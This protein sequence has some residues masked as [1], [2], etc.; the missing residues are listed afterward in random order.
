MSPNTGQNPSSDTSAVP[1]QD[2][3]VGFR[4]AA[5]GVTDVGLRRTENQDS[6]LITPTVFAVADGMGGHEAGELASA[7]AVETLEELTF[8]TDRTPENPL[9]SQEQVRKQ[10]QLADDRI[11]E[12]L[13]A[14]GGTT[15]CAL[16]QVRG[17][18]AA[19]DTITAPIAVPPW[20]SSF[21]REQTRTDVLPQVTAN[22][23]DDYRPGPNNA[24]SVRPQPSLL[25]VNVGDSRGYRLRDGVLQQLTRDHSAVQEMIDAGQITELE[26]RNH[27]HRNLIT[28]ALGAGADSQPDTMMLRARIGDRYLLCSDGLSGEL[29]PEHLHALLEAYADPQA[30]ALA[31]TQAALE[32]GGRDNI[33]VIVI[34]VLPLDAPP[35]GGE[36]Q[37]ATTAQLPTVDLPGSTN[38]AQDPET[39]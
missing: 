35:A 38:P 2:A 18:E 32:A 11:R 8:Y 3:Q 27:P 19:R 12:A 30:A 24:Q 37:P 25:L 7:L 22:M 31:L 26:A 4:L 23:L 9:P 5:D 34:D 29:T 15:L 39:P 36:H 17:S 21:R 20:T 6:I 10:I 33:A 1:L 16:L 13:D 28:R 14:R